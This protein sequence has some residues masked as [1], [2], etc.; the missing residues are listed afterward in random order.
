MD[1]MQMNTMWH[2]AGPGVLVA[3]NSAMGCAFVA[4]NDRK[5]NIATGYG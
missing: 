2:W 3:K 4:K 1:M 5:L